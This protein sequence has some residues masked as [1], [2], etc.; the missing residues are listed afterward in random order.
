MSIPDGNDVPYCAQDYDDD[1]APELVQCWQSRVGTHLNCSV[2]DLQ[3]LCSCGCNFQQSLEPH[4]A[5]VPNQIDG[6]LGNAVDSQ[7][8]SLT[9][10]YSVDFSQS[11]IGGKKCIFNKRTIKV[12][13]NCC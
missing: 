10:F 11:K 1:V 6:V 5:L 2:G 13:V 9:Q 4:Q 8:W 7:V 12:S 3:I